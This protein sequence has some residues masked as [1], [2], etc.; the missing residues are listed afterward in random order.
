MP[1]PD[2]NEKYAGYCAL[3]TCIIITITV[4]IMIEILK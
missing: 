2:K 1:S 4:L 3:G